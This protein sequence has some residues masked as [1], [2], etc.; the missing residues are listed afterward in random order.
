MNIVAFT[1]AGISRPSGIPTFEELGDDFRHRLSRPLFQRD[2]MAVYET[3]LTLREACLRAQPNAAHLALARFDVPVITMNIDGLHRRAGTRDLIEIHGS[4]ETLRCGG[5]RETYPFEQAR[6]GCRCPGCDGLLEHDV[7]LY[8]DS[9]PL[10]ST[11]LDKVGGQ[12]VLLVVG[13]SFVT[14][15]A[16]YVVDHARACGREVVVINSDA[17]R[18]VPRFLEQADLHGF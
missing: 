14:S 2:P 9:I 13:T 16:G 8:G 11:A 4:M 12:G 1:G 3:L 15:T 18:E 5:C 6:R 10:L 17:E 7:V